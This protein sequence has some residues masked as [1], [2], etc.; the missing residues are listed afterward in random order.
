MTAHAFYITFH[1]WL[2]IAFLAVFFLLQLYFWDR[3]Q[4]RWAQE[5]L[6]WRREVR[7]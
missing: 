4:R 2:G 3:R 1:V 7:P 6:K 5:E